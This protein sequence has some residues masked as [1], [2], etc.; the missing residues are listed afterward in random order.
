MALQPGNYTSKREILSSRNTLWMP[1]ITLY[2]T[3]C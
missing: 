3:Q 2:Y 1:W